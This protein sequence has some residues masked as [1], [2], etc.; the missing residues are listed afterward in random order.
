LAQEIKEQQDGRHAKEQLDSTHDPHETGAL[1][2][3]NGRQLSQAERANHPIFVLGDAL[4][5]IELPAVGATGRGFA[6]RMVE[7][8]LM[9]HASHVALY[10]KIGPGVKNLRRDEIANSRSERDAQRRNAADDR[11]K[12]SGKKWLAKY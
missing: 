7:A 6:H 3:R 8:S 1:R 11:A 2:Q 4:T 12:A 10:R 9:S 5:A